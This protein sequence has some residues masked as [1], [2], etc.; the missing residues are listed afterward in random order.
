MK[1]PLKGV[2]VGLVHGQMG[3]EKRGSPRRHSI[4]MR[5]DVLVSTTVIE[6]GMRCATATVMVVKMPN[7]LDWLNCTNCE[8]Q[9]A[10]ID[11]QVTAF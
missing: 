7:A 2:R 5:L 9:S 3:Q 8:A 4:A 6:V 10:C 11:K 1:G